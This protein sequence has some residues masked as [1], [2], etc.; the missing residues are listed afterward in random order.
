MGVMPHI[1]YVGKTPTHGAKRPPMDILPRHYK[2]AELLLMNK[3][4]SFQT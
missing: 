3:P 1:P 4:N 2:N